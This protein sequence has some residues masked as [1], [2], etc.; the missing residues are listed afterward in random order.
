MFPESS[1]KG[2]EP[3][4]TMNF[5]MIPVAKRDDHLVYSCVTTI[6]CV[7]P[8]FRVA[9]HPSSVGVIVALMYIKHETRV[10]QFRRS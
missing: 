5:R 8:R 6:S 10:G 2:F 4:D 3:N 1:L 9:L 7:K